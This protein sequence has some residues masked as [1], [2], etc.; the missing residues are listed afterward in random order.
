MIFALFLATAFASS[1]YG[2][3][4]STLHEVYHFQCLINNGFTFVIPRCY[5]SVGCMDDNCHQNMINAKNAGMSRIDT[6]FFPCFT[7]GNVA[8]QV[9]SY[10]KELIT[11]SVQ[12]ERTWFD[13]EGEWSSSTTTNQVF[14][15]EMINK[16]RSIGFVH[17]IYTN[18]YQYIY[19][20]GESYIFKYASETQLWYPIYDFEPSLD[21]LTM[22]GGW[23]RPNI[24]QYA[25]NQNFCDAWVDFN[26]QE[27]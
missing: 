12:P 20:F 19:F 2:V 9:A 1:M 6:Y 25:G 14:L 11:Y 17:G 4:I 10:Y 16:A 23:T 5:C 22:F 26:Y 7:C 27:L 15:M 13:V 3:D 21:G 24:K 18:Y 8:G